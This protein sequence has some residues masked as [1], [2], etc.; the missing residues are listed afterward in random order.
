MSEFEFEKIS[1]SNP[2]HISTEPRANILLPLKRIKP[3]K[4]VVLKSRMNVENILTRTGALGDGSCFF[5]SLLYCISTEY[6]K[7]NLSEKILVV[8]RIRENLSQTITCE[9]WENLNNGLI[10]IVMFQEQVNISLTDFYSFIQ[11]TKIK[12][13]KTLSSI[14]KQTNLDKN[15]LHIY[16]L[17][18]D[19]LPITIFE[20]NILPESYKIKGNIDRI[21]KE[22]LKNTIQYFYKKD[23][24]RK[25]QVSKAR[26]LET[27]LKKIIEI[28]LKTSKQKSYEKYV[29][30]VKNPKV[31]IDTFLIDFIS[32]KFN[33]N[34]YF[35]D[36]ETRLPYKNFSNHLDQKRKSL[37]FV[38][39]NRNH[40]E[41]IGILNENKTITREF[42]HDHPLISKIRQHLGLKNIQDDQLK[43]KIENL[44]LSFEEDSDDECGVSDSSSSSEDEEC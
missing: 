35:I 40:F 5:H 33:R 30:S 12:D 27:Y 20:K 2:S 42:L 14:I 4:T 10:S 26:Y 18:A 29:S 37:V 32:D 21:S 16:Q 23:E 1:G 39:V 19:L 38:W 24:I 25:I 36:G 28:V 43:S 6:R 7:H 41:S 44:H 17:I 31:N 15:N 22:I 13:P 9:C 34:I 3:D 8:K 11:N